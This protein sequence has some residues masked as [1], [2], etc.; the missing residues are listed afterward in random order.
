MRICQLQNILSSIFLTIFLISCSTPPRVEKHDDRLITPN[1]FKVGPKYTYRDLQ[2]NYITHP[3][4]DVDPGITK[5]I[6]E[7]R[8]FVST[9][10]DSSYKYNFDLLSGHLYKDRDFCA[11][12]DIWDV[13]KGEV[14]KPNFT[15]GIVP[16]IFDQ[17]SDPQRIVVFSD[18]K[19]VEKFKLHPTNYDTA[20]VLGSILIEKCESFPCDQNAKWT[21]SQILVAVN[22]HDPEFSAIK[23]IHELKSKVDWV[24]FR[25][26]IQSLEGVHQ[27]G[28]QFFPAFK[29]SHELNFEETVRYFVINSVPL[30]MDELSKMRLG[31]FDLYDQIWETTEKIRSEKSEQQTKFLNFFKEFYAKNSAKYY[32]CQKL[33]GSAS[34]NENPRRFWFFTYL[35]AFTNMEK[36]GFYYSCSQKSWF[37]NPKVD[38]TKNFVDQNNELAR[39][40][41]RD[42]EKS[43][44]Q[45]INGLSLMKNQINK[46]YRFIEYDTQHGGSHQKI[47]NWVD[48]GGKV[49]VCKNPK[50]SSQDI[51]FEIFPQ[52]VV[53]P[54]FAPDNDKTIN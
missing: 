45:A 5:N 53:W 6:E 49:T 24:Y 40:K 33:V 1:W 28:K 39:C 50:D 30:K 11:T 38:E 42:F 54:S 32:S 23:Y 36:N 52:D 15:M 3:F 25:A 46:S 8:Y 27:M 12:E 22:S 14:S 31:C 43:F 16:R 2:D 35:S 44:D 48:V 19:E 26:F 51:P 37:Y 47:Y 7:L 4:Y 18:P 34:I 20:K 13:Y 17:N 29:I 41:P 9:P 10:E 21:P